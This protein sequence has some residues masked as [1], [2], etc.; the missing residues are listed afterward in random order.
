MSR[1][2]TGW[3]WLDGDVAVGLIVAMVMLRRWRHL[4]TFLGSVLVLD[5]GGRRYRRLSRPRPYD[6]TVIGRWQGYLDAV[7]AGRGR[8][9]TIVGVVYTL[10]VPGGPGPSPS[11]HRCR[12]RVRLRRLYLGVDHPSDVFVGVALGVAI[13][14]ERVPLLHARTR[15][16]P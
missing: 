6:V 9:F 4:F 13:P 16:F 8:R 10:V 2:S 14:L 3:L 1:P 11:V 5:A 12:R 15:S 7:A